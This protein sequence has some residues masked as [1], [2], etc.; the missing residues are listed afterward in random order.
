MRKQKPPELQIDIFER[1]PQ[2]DLFQRRSRQA[3]LELFADTLK[4][5]ATKL[6]TEAE[7]TAAAYKAGDPRA[8]HRPARAAPVGPFAVIYSAYNG[9]LSSKPN[10]FE[11]PPVLT[12]E[13]D[14]NSARI[15]D[16]GYQTLDEARQAAEAVG[17]KIH[18]ERS[19]Y[20]RVYDQST[21]ELVRPK[22]EK[23]EKAPRR[24]RGKLPAFTGPE[25]WEKNL[26][27]GEIAWADIY[28]DAS[29]GGMRIVRNDVGE[30]YRE[31]DK[32]NEER[33]R[34]MFADGWM[35]VK[36]ATMTGHHGRGGDTNED[37]IIESARV[38]EPRK[39][40][41]V[42]LAALRERVGLDR[43][44]F[45]RTVI[46]LANHGRIVLSRNDNTPSITP[47]DEVAAIWVGG[48][49]RHLI[50]LNG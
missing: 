50:Y 8:K 2:Q 43:R 38:L 49:P 23:A 19:K 34:R 29:W 37:A 14:R 40:G 18:D 31:S 13:L 47:E 42:P 10:P 17:R 25:R 20:V 44:T 41:P 12:A 33:R 36:S 5:A 21:G 32:D 6:R 9:I 39:G 45:D 4:G 16:T 22:G 11:Y 30:N 24:A 28:P 27:G 15:W 3:G 1:D 35:V 7:A 46:D 48:H 26:G